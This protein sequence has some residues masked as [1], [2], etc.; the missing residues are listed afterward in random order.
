MEEL[1]R[2]KRAYAYR[3]LAQVEDDDHPRR[4]A[5]ALRSDLHERSQLHQL[6]A[7]LDK[8][9]QPQHVRRVAIRADRGKWRKPYWASG[10]AA[11]LLTP[12]NGKKGTATAICGGPKSIANI[13]LNQQPSD[14]RRGYLD[15]GATIQRNFPITPNE[16]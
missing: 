13:S 8:R 1:I 5:V 7:T 14:A 11:R 12:L 10:T 16:L 2:D 6:C 9:E 15:T 4:I 3:K